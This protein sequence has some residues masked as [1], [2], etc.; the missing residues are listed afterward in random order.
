MSLLTAVFMTA[1]ALLPVDPPQFW[2]QVDSAPA[3]EVLGG[4]A[5]VRLVSEG[6]AYMGI[7]EGKPGMRVPEHTHPTSIEMIYVLEGGGIMT[8]G[9]KRTVVRPGMAIQVPAGTKHS[10]EIPQ[11]AKIN[12]KG[13]QVYTPSGPEQRFKKGIRINPKGA[14][15]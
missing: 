14:T 11:D 6:K 2:G 15:P 12:F 5:V 3:Y 7:M 1:L 4:K 8:V 10:F 9:G 13:V